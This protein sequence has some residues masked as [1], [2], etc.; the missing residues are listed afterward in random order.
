MG[1]VSVLTPRDL[2]RHYRETRA[3][4]WAAPVPLPSEKPRLLPT[5][6]DNMR[7]LARLRLETKIIREFLTEHG[8]DIDSVINRK[9]RIPTGGI[10]KVS[11]KEILDAVCRRFLVRHIDLIAARRTRALVIP[12]HV[13][14]YLARSHTGKSLPEIGRHVG[15]R[16][17]TTVLHGVKRIVSM[18]RIDPD[19][20]H[21]IALL[22]VE[23]GM[24][25]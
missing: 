11:M 19:L 12:R 8:I 21:D 6:A 13:V 20:A 1:A 15:N 2:S 18:I 17:H 22:E 25:A 3:R 9:P 16:D 14:F 4:L 5:Q 23:L 24:E 7:E 10:S